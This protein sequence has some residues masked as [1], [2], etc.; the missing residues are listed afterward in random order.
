MESLPK[1]KLTKEEMNYFAFWLN[2]IGSKVGD[3]VGSFLFN[4]PS[5]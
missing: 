5:Q 2:E 3:K 4:F 1:P